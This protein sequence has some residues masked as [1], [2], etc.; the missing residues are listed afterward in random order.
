MTAAGD[1]RPSLNA[2]KSI[3]VSLPRYRW[4]GGVVYIRVTSSFRD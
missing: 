1:H 2:I 3:F 4:N